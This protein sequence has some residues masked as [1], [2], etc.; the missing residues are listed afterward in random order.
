MMELKYDIFQAYYEARKNKRHTHN[1]LLFEIE[2]ESKLLELYSEI[3]NGNYKVGKSI[4]FIVEEPVKREIFAA[5]F[6]DRVVHHLLFMYI[7][8]ILE[9]AFIDDSYSCRKG[10]GTFIGIQRAYENLSKVSHNFT[11]CAYI[12]KLDIQGYFMSINKNILLNKLCSMISPQQ[13]IESKKSIDV[14]HLEYSLGYDALFALLQIVIK[15]DPTNN[16]F[17]KGNQADW[18]GLPESK[19]LFKASPNCGLPIGNLTSQLFSNVY[20]NDFDHYIKKSLGIEYYGRYVDDFYILH[21]NK[22]YLKY[23]LS[24]CKRYLLDEGLEIHPKKIYLQHYTKGFQFLGAYI[25]PHRIYIGKRTAGKFKK[26]IYTYKKQI[27]EEHFSV[28]EIQNMRAVLN[29]Y[30]GLMSHYKTYHLRYNSIFKKNA[31]AFQK[32]GFFSENLNKIILYS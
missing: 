13:Y 20:L 28:K 1:Q 11:R 25:K 2:Y 12:L 24:E 8:P 32:Y 9:S 4:A 7:N 21:P 30:L 29:S 23:I 5:D 16:C 6:R 18:K 31:N 14:D 19:S 22:N 27:E 26:L 15:N 3:K 10:K 17:I